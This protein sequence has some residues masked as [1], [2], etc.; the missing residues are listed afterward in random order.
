MDKMLNSS[1][2]IR[3]NDIFM[4]DGQQISSDEKRFRSLFMPIFCI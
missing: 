1:P 2:K 4:M 3:C